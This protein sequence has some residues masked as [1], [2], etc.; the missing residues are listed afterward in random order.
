[1][2]P[3]VWFATHARPIM[4][5]WQF[6]RVSLTSQHRVATALERRVPDEHITLK[7]FPLEYP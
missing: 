7:V 5:Y 1:M 6:D 2:V 4:P 3:F